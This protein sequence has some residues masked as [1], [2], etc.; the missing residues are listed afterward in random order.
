MAEYPDQL[1]KLAAIA[2]DMDLAAELRIKAIELLAKV[3]TQ[4][5]LRVLLDLAAND[6]LI[7]QE[8]DI[9]LKHARGIIKSG[10]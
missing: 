10:H 7:K 4:E 3:G 5:A 1:K 2:T 8:R 6:H 9:A